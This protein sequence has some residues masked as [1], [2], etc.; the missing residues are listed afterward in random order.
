MQIQVEAA[1]T[2]SD[3]RLRFAKKWFGWALI[4]LVI[5]ASFGALMRYKYAFP[6]PFFNQTFLIHAHSHFAFTGWVSHFLYTSLALF[7]LP[8]SAN[9]FRKKYNLLI[10]LNLISAY[11]ML[12]AFTVQGY[13][14]ISITFSTLSLVMGIVFAYHFIRDSRFLLPHHRVKPWLITGSLINAFSSLGPFAL[15][16]MMASNTM[17]HDAQNIAIHFFLHF[18]YNGWFFFGSIALIAA[19]LPQNAPSLKPF[20]WVFLICS[21]CTYF[22]S[23][24]WANIPNWIYSI[25]TTASIVQAV[26]WFMLLYR[27]LPVFLSKITYQTPRW[28]LFILHAATFSLSLKFIL[29][30]LSTIPDWSNLVFGF[31]PMIIAYLHLVLLGGYT[32]FFIGYLLA[33][34]YILPTKLAQVSISIFLTGIFLNELFLG[35]Q[36]V[37]VGVF[38]T[39]FR[40]V[41]DWLFLAALFLLIGAVLIAIC[42]MPKKQN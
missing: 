29:E 6:I 42:G 30:I 33:K 41:N 25:A 19:F 24:L 4:S 32:L 37:I 21:I 1:S 9:K 5:V 15:A 35:L 13:K 28:I 38:H 3:Q 36:S 16:Y 31:R 11:G 2:P 12:F 14:A 8:Y 39:P 26:A 7:L 17:T 22:L 10:V 34:G 23:I 20:L 40:Q 18:Q 27:F